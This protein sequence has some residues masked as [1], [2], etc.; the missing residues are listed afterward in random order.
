MSLP[1]NILGTVDVTDFS[2]K[3]GLTVVGDEL[4]FSTNEGSFGTLPIPTDW[5]PMV[6]VQHF[7][8]EVLNYMTSFFLLFLDGATLV[9]EVRMFVLFDNGAMHGKILIKDNDGKL[10]LSLEDWS[11]L[12][13]IP[14]GITHCAESPMI[15]DNQN[16]YLIKEGYDGENGCAVARLFM[17]KEK[18]II[19]ITKLVFYESTPRIETNQIELSFPILSFGQSITGQNL[20]RTRIECPGYFTG[21][22][23]S[24]FTIKIGEV[25]Y[26]V[27]L[28][29]G[30]FKDYSVDHR[31]GHYVL[32]AIYNKETCTTIFC[33]DADACELIDQEMTRRGIFSIQIPEFVAPKTDNYSELVDALRPLPE[34]LQAFL[35]SITWRNPE[36]AGSI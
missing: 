16:V 1:E 20:F 5:S 4:V 36:A 23:F 7:F 34:D 3:I 14:Q 21:E 30:D 15:I 13:F 22:Y 11:E 32:S 6:G 33:G 8:F 31:D 10:E 26:N 18:F 2:S 17:L 28:S 35:S 9:G 27:C 24:D 29:F 25:V 12:S 19:F